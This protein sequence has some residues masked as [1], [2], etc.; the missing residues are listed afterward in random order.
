MTFLEQD[1]NSRLA[2]KLAQASD[3]HAEEL[4]KE[5]AAAAKRYA[6]AVEKERV[7]EEAKFKVDVRMAVMDETEKQLQI[8]DKK[9]AAQAKAHQDE[10]K[11]CQLLI[12]ALQ[13]ENEQLKCNLTSSHSVSLPPPPQLTP[14]PA[15]AAAS[16]S[17]A[18]VVI[19]H[20][21]GDGDDGE[22]I[23]QSSEEEAPVE[24]E[25]E[26]GGDNNEEEE[27]EGEEDGTGN[28]VSYCVCYSLV[29]MH[30]LPTGCIV[31]FCNCLIRVP[32]CVS[33]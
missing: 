13:Q 19:S 17:A 1:Y 24:E 16:S 33:Q 27:E 6:T 32:I 18:P 30:Y 8:C 26:S 21:E 14:C 15:A 10:L 4:K 29:E 5:R 3:K 9:L 28:L 22:N 11:Q 25:E 12:V 23:E 7:S 20:E 31:V 2:E